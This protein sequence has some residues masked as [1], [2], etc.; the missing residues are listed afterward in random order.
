[1]PHR[2]ISIHTLHAEG[3]LS[4]I[5]LPGYLLISIHTLH[6]EGDLLADWM[7]QI[8]N[9]SIHT[10]HAEGDRNI[11]FFDFIFVHILRYGRLVLA[12][13][14]HKH[15]AFLQKYTYSGANFTTDLCLLRIRTGI[16]TIKSASN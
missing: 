15:N 6:A 16:Y 1:M 5:G 3:D 2:A 7:Q 13:Q 12:Y 8:K 11:L 14:C 4:T 10:L 9:I